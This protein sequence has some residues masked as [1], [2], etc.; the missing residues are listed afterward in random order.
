M[1]LIMGSAFGPA[2]AI[3]ALSGESVNTG[4]KGASKGLY[5]TWGEWLTGGS[6]GWSIP[7][8]FTNPGYLITSPLAINKTGYTWRTGNGSTVRQNLQK[9]INQEIKDFTKNINN[10]SFIPAQVKY[11]GSTV[12]KSYGAKTNSNL[13]DPRVKPLSKPIS[14]AERLG[15]PKG[16]RSNPKV[17]EDPQY[18][19]YQQWNQRYNTAIESGNVKEVQRLRDLHFKIKAPSTKVV[20]EGE[21]PKEVYHFTNTPIIHKFD[22]KY[23]RDGQYP[24]Y[25]TSDVN[26]RSIYAPSDAYQKS[27]LK[28]YLKMDRP[29]KEDLNKTK[30][31]YDYYALDKTMKTDP[32]DREEIRK[33]WRKKYDDLFDLGIDKDLRASNPKEA[34]RLFNE[35]SDIWFNNIHNRYGREFPMKQSEIFD[36]SRNKDFESLLKQEFQADGVIHNVNGTTHY[37]TYKPEFI[38]FSK[39]MTYDDNGNLIPIVKRDNFRNLD[40]RYKQGGILKGQTGMVLGSA[41]LENFSRSDAVKNAMNNIRK[42]GSDLKRRINTM[43]RYNPE[44]VPV[45]GQPGVTTVRRAKVGPL[46]SARGKDPKIV[47]NGGEI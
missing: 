46:V 16:E 22:W 13:I 10:T 4:V 47:E 34:K 41:L 25:F 29:L 18:W 38:K 3:A 7:A 32:I 28:V 26:G 2:G 1:P 39:M 8:E 14:E 17:L 35:A 12:G 33:F 45:I 30:R 43:N 24:I 36:L 31:S 19:G 5:N 6:K 21:M 37:I 11:Y 27:K 44:Q 9:A 23:K 42:W 15:I 20:N 40:M